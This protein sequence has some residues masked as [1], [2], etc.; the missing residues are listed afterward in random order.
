MRIP[1]LLAPWVLLGLAGCGGSSSSP[2]PGER[3]LVPIEHFIGNPQGPLA[4]KPSPGKTQV[5]FLQSS[6]GVHSRVMNLFVQQGTEAPVQVTS[7]I[8][9]NVF[10]F[11]WFNENRLGFLRDP[12]GSEGYRLYGVNPDGSRFQELTPPHLQGVDTEPLCPESP[13]ADRWLVAIGPTHGTK[14]L[15][16]I[17]VVTGEF[18]LKEKNPGNIR[19]LLRSPDGKMLLAWSMDGV[20]NAML[21]RPHEGA[22]FRQVGQSAAYPD[23]LLPCRLEGGGLAVALSNLGR[24]KLVKVRMN[25]ADGQIT[26]VLSRDPARDVGA[27]ENPPGEFSTGGWLQANLGPRAERAGTLTAEALPKSDGLGV[28]VSYESRDGLVIHAFLHLPTGVLPAKLPAVI[29][30][31]GGPAAMVAHG[32]DPVARFLASRGLVVLEPNFRGSSGFGKEFEAAGFGQWGRAMQDDL[33]DGVKWL[34][35]NGLADPARIGIVGASYGGYAA[36]A[37]A[38]LH[39]WTYRCAVA[40][41]GPSNLLTFLA[42]PYSMGA[43]AYLRMVVGDPQSDADR[44]REVSP[45]LHAH[46]VRIPILIA[47]GSRDSRVPIAESEQMVAALQAQG[48]PVEY[49]AFPEEGHSYWCE[50][51]SLTLFRAVER[52]LGEHL[53]SRV[54]P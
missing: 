52:F 34:V 24:D 1:I 53:G 48:K 49:L 18:G 22:P 13:G 25:L 23:L 54:A 17:D 12:D 31:H 46:Q 4:R 33:A 41:A 42:A 11:N 32:G 39:P 43:T 50:N 9:R 37:G 51:T 14:D 38:T 35:D 21:Y 29:L 10:R 19:R 8:D 5:A 28:P 6:Q 15:Y 36:L 26:R 40:I 30:C 45:A 2:S 27:E 3:N 47:H 44:L 16:W 7:G 20:N